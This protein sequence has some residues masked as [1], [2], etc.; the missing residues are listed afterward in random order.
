[1]I[2]N[3][4]RKTQEPFFFTNAM[5]QESFEDWVNS[6]FPEARK[7]GDVAL[8]KVILGETEWPE[9]GDFAALRE[10]SIDFACGIIELHSTDRLQPNL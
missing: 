1:M 3:T 4:E 5:L 6:R 2:G 7:I 8:V 10:S 9:G